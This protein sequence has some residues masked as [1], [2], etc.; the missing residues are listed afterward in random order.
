MHALGEGLGEPVGKRLRQD[1]GIVV[2]GAGE[3]LGDGLLAD[4][5]GHREAADEI[6]EAGLA[7]RDEIGERHMGAL[8]GSS[9]RSAGGAYR[10]APARR[11]RVSSA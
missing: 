11:S 2:I 5:G 3:A 4:A 1:L 7:R 10:A 6:G 9:A 8:V